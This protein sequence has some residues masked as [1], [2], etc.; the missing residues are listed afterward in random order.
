MSFRGILRDADYPGAGG[1]AVGT[2]DGY[3]EGASVFP[4][5]LAGLSAEEQR[6]LIRINRAGLAALKDY[7]AANKAV[8][9]LGAGTSMPL[10]PLWNG[11]IKEVVEAA[12]DRL[13]ERAVA[14]C[15]A[16]ASHNPDAVVEIVRRELGLQAYREVLRQVFRVRRDPGTGHTWTPLQEQIAR[17]NFLGVV[18]TNYDPGIVNARMAVRPLASGT[19]FASYTDEDALDRWRTGDVFGDAELPVLYA[20]GHHNQ[21]DA[22]V[23]ATTE[24]RRAYSG[25]L[26]RVLGRLVDS[27]HLVWVGFSFSDQRIGAI[28][29][30]I[31]EWSGQRIE[32]G[33][34][35]RHVAFLSWDP[36]P[37]DGT[38]AHEPEIIRDV[39]E[40]QYGCKV[41]LYPAYGTD[42]TALGLL[43]DEFTDSRF[44]APG[45]TTLEST[46]ST[47]HSH[48]EVG[49]RSVS[50][51]PPPPSSLRP[52]ASSATGPRIHWVHGGAPVEHFTGR[53]EEL[54]FLDRWAADP[55]VHLIGVTAWGGAGK[56][57]L[58]TEWLTPKDALP[59]STVRGLFAWSFYEEPSVEAWTQALFRWAETTF[60]YPAET[61]SIADRLLALAKR[62]PLILVLDGLEVTQEGPAGTMFGRLLDGALRSILIGLCQSDHSSLAVLT[63][64]FPFADLEP[65]NGTAARML[66][67]P[68]FTP[69]EGVELLRRAGGDWLSMEDR[70]R[71]VLAVDGHALALSALAGTLRD[72]PAD[73]NVGV[74]LSELDRAKRTDTRVAHVLRFYADRLAP[75]DRYLVALVSLFQRPVSATTVLALGVHEALGAPLSGW[76]VVQVEEASRRRLAGVLTWHPDGSISAHPLVRDAFRPLALSAGTAQLASQTALADLPA[77]L[78]GS[79]ED[80]QKVVEMIELLL[81]AGQWEAARELFAGRAGYGH[82]WMSLPAARLGQ[83]SASA[84]VATRERRSTC[85]SRLSL[86]DLVSFLSWTGTYAMISGDLSA[87]E[88]FLRQAI[89]YAGTDKN[90]AR[91]LS[92]ELNLSACLTFRGET[93]SAIEAAANA[94]NRA[95]QDESRRYT[96]DAHGFIATA[97]DLAGQTVAA[98]EHFTS[99]SR[100][101]VRA[102]PEAGHIYVLIGTR[103]GEMLLRTGRGIAARNLGEQ[104]RTLCLT[105]GW[106]DALARCD[107]LLAR[108]D[109]ADGDVDSAG[110]RLAQASTVF[111]DGDYLVDLAAAL[112]DLSEH[113]RRAG[114]LYAGEQFCLEAISLASSRQLVPSHARALCARARI[115]ADHYSATG[116][117]GHYER[118]RDD[119]EHALRLVSTSVHLP[120]IELEATQAHALLDAASKEDGGWARKA[121]RLQATLMPSGLDPNSFG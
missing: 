53:R 20:H 44:T 79:R 21:P 50:T 102:T 16:M 51:A 11:V 40:I 86:R 106:N 74:L 1:H 26:A 66:E 121:A 85:L 77:G 95:A 91:A 59:R 90:T 39:M 118:A 115:R 84:F 13:S 110:R 47:A 7:L 61:G 5:Y 28:I 80:G 116:D 6:R 23:L 34:P 120:W 93:E 48:Q 82:I 17:C 70:V 27:E 42:H 9:F 2:A 35:P 72:R 32:P 73:T 107:L 96:R 83:R 65:F 25:K 87:A 14:T 98:E 8:A 76:D 31:S 109:L 101:D 45:W 4:A 33:S 99:A 117:S 111:R 105:N 92:I 119:A 108:C 112:P 63:S 3:E 64:R 36:A 43:L 12:S 68:A 97:L 15:L 78:I 62:F 46:A 104:N 94:L 58:V 24:Y 114:D 30:E 29:R 113:R 69:D 88:S 67:V 103:R 56:T 57:A 75:A 71:L 10:Y 89:E 37:S 52:E 81:D 60:R 38:E 100:I 41:V 54:A 55:E 18:T 19:G 22:I 49:A